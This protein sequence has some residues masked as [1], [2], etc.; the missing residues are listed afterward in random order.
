MTYK[1]YTMHFMSDCYFSVLLLTKL[2][3]KT[4][5][6]RKDSHLHHL[7]SFHCTF[8]CLSARSVIDALRL[9][10]SYAI[11]DYD[12]T[13]RRLVLISKL[14]FIIL[15]WL[16]WG[17]VFCSRLFTKGHLKRF[18]HCVYSGI[19][20]S[21]DNVVSSARYT[22][23]EVYLCTTGKIKSYPH[24]LVNVEFTTVQLC[25][26]FK[27]QSRESVTSNW[28]NCCCGITSI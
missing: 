22:T 3:Y 8:D 20:S 24:E 16:V 2:P 17:T 25:L 6:Y 4:P 1:Y 21:P 15:L 5:K 14:S 18:W 26:A 11:S 23:L 28:E 19:E 13:S 12:E 9:L 7:N 27:Q 10:D